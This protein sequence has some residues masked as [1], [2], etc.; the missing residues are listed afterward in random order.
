[1]KKAKMDFKFPRGNKA[2]CHVND[3]YYIAGGWRE[4][5]YLK[6]LWKITH[7]LEIEDLCPMPIEKHSFPMAYFK[8]NN[9][10]ITLGGKP[11]KGKL[12]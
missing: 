1:M 10:L 8:R 2:F 9:A 5:E 7:R 4:N 12:K 6:N 11:L 3:D